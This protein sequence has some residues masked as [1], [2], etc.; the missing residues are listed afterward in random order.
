ASAAEKQLPATKGSCCLFLGYP[1]V[2][3]WFEQRIQTTGRGGRFSQKDIGSIKVAE[4]SHPMGVEDGLA[5]GNR[6]SVECADR[7]ARVVFEVIEIR[8]VVALVHALHE[9]EMDF[10]QI[11][12][13][14]KNAPDVFG[15]EMAR[16]LFGRPIHD[17]IDVQFRTDL[18]DGSCE[19]HSVIL[20]FQRTG[21][22]GEMLLQ[23]SAQERCVELGFEAEV[24]PNDHRLHIGIHHYADDAL[25]KP[26]Y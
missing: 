2:A 4:V 26:R 15:I 20:W 10:H 3:C 7:T 8:R 12:E 19:S 11:F 24:V 22:Q 25:F 18:P 1:D 9:S 23:I 16:H 13:P 14:V 5:S 17:K 21:L 6:K